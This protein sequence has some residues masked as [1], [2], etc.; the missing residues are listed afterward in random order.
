MD[1]ILRETGDGR[2]DPWD[3]DWELEEQLLLASAPSAPHLPLLSVLKE[4]SRLHGGMH[5]VGF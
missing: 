5:L 2:A 3:Q 1:F 4:P